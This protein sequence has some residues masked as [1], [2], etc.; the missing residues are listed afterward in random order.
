MYKSNSINNRYQISISTKEQDAE[1]AFH[2]HDVYAVELGQ[3]ETNRVGQLRDSLD[4]YNVNVVVSVSGELV[5]FISLTPPNKHSFSI[6]KYFKRSDLPF[7]VDESIWESRLLTVFKKHRGSVIVGLLMYGALRWVESHGGKKIVIIGH[8]RISKM[9]KR[10]GFE[11]SGLST[12]SGALT[13]DLM[14]GTVSQLRAK[15]EEQGKTLNKILSQTDWQLPVSFNPPVPCFH[16]GAFFKAIGDCFD[17]LD[18]KNS[19]VNADV[20]DAWFP[21]SPKIISAINENLSWLLRTS[22]PT[23]CEGFL[24]K[25]ATAR[26]VTP[27][28]VLPGAGSSDL[29]FRAFRLWLKESSK[30]LILDPTYGEYSHVIEKVVRCKV[31]RVRLN[32]EN[33]FA[34][35]LNDFEQALKKKYDL[36]VLVN[37]NSPTGKHLSKENMIRAISQIPLT[38]RV[39][40]DET[41]VEYVGSD[42][43]LEKVAA[44]SENI[45]VC[46]SMSKVYALS[47]ARVA[48]LC[49]GQHQIEPLRTITPPWVISMPAQLAGVY[50]LDDPSYYEARYKE[51]HILKEA[52]SSELSEIGLEVFPSV[53]NF[54]LCKLPEGGKCA[55]DIVRMCVT[56]GVYLRNAST[57]GTSIRANYLRIAV[58]NKVDNKRI[59][60]TLKTAING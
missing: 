21:P 45:I 11:P 3:H 1:L 59:V 12:Q 14:L 2:R 42:Q 49:G 26:G 60:D 9:Y 56:K 20:L 32:Y 58:K 34:L 29:I 18:R 51:T 33:E 53:A 48:Y 23:G 55:E 41:Y 6:D 24:S 30:V 47:G 16:G 19:I 13:Y 35:D 39:W 5:G 17:H 28:N 10:L 43:S 31:D 52:F 44:C 57:M 54:L 37:P 27:C 7:T 22:P 50:A 36:I 8:R 38:T 25:V 46:K 4:A 40:V 15:S